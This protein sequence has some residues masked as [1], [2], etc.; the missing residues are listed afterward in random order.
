MLLDAYGQRRGSGAPGTFPPL[1]GACQLVQASIYEVY[2]SPL[3]SLLCGANHDLPAGSRRLMVYKR[4][5]D[6]EV[7]AAALKAF[8]AREI[9]APAGISADEL[10][11]FRKK[12]FAAFRDETPPESE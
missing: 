5:P 3:P 7:S 10:N 4:I 11:P 12:Y 2:V 1:P 6:S 8:E 9:A